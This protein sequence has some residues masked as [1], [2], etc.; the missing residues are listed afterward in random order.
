MD[1]YGNSNARCLGQGA[2]ISGAF[3]HASYESI[4]GQQSVTCFALYT[5]SGSNSGEPLGSKAINLSHSRR[6][7]L[8]RHAVKRRIILVQVRNDNKRR[9]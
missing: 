1:L 5:W 2:M 3:E 6:C 9:Q 4:Y 7:L 8:L